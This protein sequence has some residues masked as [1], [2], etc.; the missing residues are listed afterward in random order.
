MKLLFPNYVSGFQAIIDI[1]D[2][3]VDHGREI[4]V[5]LILIPYESVD[6]ND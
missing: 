5:P 3:I 2:E 4:N 1:I 6:I